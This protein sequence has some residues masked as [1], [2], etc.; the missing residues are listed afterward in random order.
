[1]GNTLFKSIGLAVAYKTV[2]AGLVKGI[3]NACRSG[4]TEEEIKKAES[5]VYAVN[6]ANTPEEYWRL[7]KE[8]ES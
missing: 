2:Q 8:M 3:Q 7:R 6:Y 1:M 5:V 4:C